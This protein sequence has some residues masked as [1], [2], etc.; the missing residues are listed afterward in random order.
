MS[1]IV[2][3]PEVKS[4]EMRRSMVSRATV[5]QSKVS[6][7]LAPIP[8]EVEPFNPEAIKELRT[9]LNAIPIITPEERQGRRYCDCGGPSDGSTMIPCNKCDNLFHE[10]NLKIN[11][12]SQGRNGWTCKSCTSVGGK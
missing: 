7:T 1:I 12:T 2:K 9:G 8:G 11:D 10:K 3:L 5:W 4:R 6:K